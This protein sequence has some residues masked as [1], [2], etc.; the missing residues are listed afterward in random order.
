VI[1]EFKVSEVTALGRRVWIKH[2]PDAPLLVGTKTWERIERVFAPLFEARDA[3][4]GYK[5][6]LVLVALIRARREHTYEIDAASL[7]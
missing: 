5:V 1:G 3:D 6:R 7:M 2:M 4:S